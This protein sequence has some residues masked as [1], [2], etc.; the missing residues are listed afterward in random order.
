[1]EW[2]RRH[3]QVP[4][5]A[6]AVQDVCLVHV[7]KRVYVRPTY[8]QRKR[9]IGGRTGKQLKQIPLDTA[10]NLVILS[11]KKIDGRQVIDGP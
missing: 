11:K 6:L 10:S 3:G 2:V 9:I 4:G 5:K 7:K 1:M 8:Y